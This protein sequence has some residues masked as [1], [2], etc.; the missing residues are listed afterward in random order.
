M[1]PVRMISS[2]MVKNCLL[3]KKNPAFGVFHSIIS[4]NA[5]VLSPEHSRT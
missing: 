5:T 4:D 1:Y 2:E 3:E